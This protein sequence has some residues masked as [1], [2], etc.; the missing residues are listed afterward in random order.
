MFEEEKD[1]VKKYWKEAGAKN[2]MLIADMSFSMQIDD[3]IITIFKDSR[4]DCGY[5]VTTWAENNPL[6][7]STM[8]SNHQLE[9][10]NMFCYFLE[11]LLVKGE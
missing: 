3:R 8:I 11:G 4:S 7:T 5:S 2:L 1:K 6:F 10:A 9:L